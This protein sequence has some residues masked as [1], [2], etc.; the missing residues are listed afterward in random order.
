MNL[1]HVHTQ[2]CPGAGPAFLLGLV[3][4]IHLFIQHIYMDVDSVV[5]VGNTTVKETKLLLMNH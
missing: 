4:A 5:G 3:R 1:A 2:Q